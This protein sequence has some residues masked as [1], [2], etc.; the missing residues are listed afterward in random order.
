[1]LDHRDLRTEVRIQRGELHANVA[2]ANHHHLPR[3]AGKLHERLADEHVA[4][5]GKPC[6]TEAVTVH[7]G[8][9][10]NRSVRARVN[11]YLRSLYLLDAPVGQ[12]HANMVAIDE[13]RRSINHGGTGQV[14]ELVVVLPAQTPGQFTLGDNRL[15]VS[16]RLVLE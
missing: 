2:A 12:G 10:G 14:R 15:G 8:N 16:Q 7:A 9:G 4:A 1:M 6:T 3:Q 5:R 11:E 13:L